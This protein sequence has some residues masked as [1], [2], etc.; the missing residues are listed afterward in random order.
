VLQLI[1]SC[2]DKSCEKFTNCTTYRH[3]CFEHPMALHAEHVHVPA[4]EGDEMS[5]YTLSALLYT[6]DLG[7]S[8]LH[9]SGADNWKLA[10]PSV[11]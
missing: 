5:D 6:D 11:L 7:Q 8:R 3:D 1:S 2:F 9:Y 4:C 10:A